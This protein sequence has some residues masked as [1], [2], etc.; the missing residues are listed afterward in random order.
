MVPQT[1]FTELLAD[2][3]PSPTTKTNASGAHNAVRNHLRTHEAFQD[4]W[5]GDFLAG[6]YA[7]NTAIRPKQTAD[8]H[9][10]A[11]VDIIVETSFSTT[12]DPEDVLDELCDAL[13]D[14]F[15]VER[16]N[17]RSV[18]V[19]TSRAEIDVVPVVRTATGF[20]LPDRDLGY[21]KSTNPPA[22]T[23]W[24]SEQNTRFSGRFKPL[25]KLFKWWRRENKTGKRPKG[26]VLEVLVALHAP[27]DQAHYGEA[28]AQML[29][30]IHA[31]YGSL[32]ALGAKPVVGDPGLY[33][34]G[35]ILSKVS[36]TDW[37]AF[38]ERVRVHAGYAR[39][40]QDTDD[41]EEAT[42]LWR[43]LFG[44]R[45]KSTENPPKAVNMSSTTTASAA[46]GG[47]MFPDANATPTKPRGFA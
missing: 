17:K 40:A 23:T 31:A 18:R 8:G 16:V 7:R 35:D 32:A 43:R 37:L 27:T 33:G 47:Y 6:S 3:E 39:R 28:F 2:I 29:A 21:W 38:M 10:R 19:V 13:E 11:D 44:D 25:V 4:R 9:E 22:H 24:S 34:T 41:M 30:N 46:T 5:E 20:E 45:F 36:K 14:C 42:G 1:R 26:F 15:T 12:D